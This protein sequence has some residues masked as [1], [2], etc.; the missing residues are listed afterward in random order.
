MPRQLVRN[1][2][3]VY[4]AIDSTSRIE[5]GS[6]PVANSV[7]T[8]SMWIKRNTFNAVSAF[9]RILSTQNPGLSVEFNENLGNLSYVNNTGR[10][11]TSTFRP[12]AKWF[13]L[14]AVR[15]ATQ[16][17]L[18][19]NGV[20]VGTQPAGTSTDTGNLVIG[21]LSNLFARAFMGN[22]SDFT[23]YNKELSQDEINNVMN[24][25]QTTGLL[26]WFKLDEGTGS[27]AIDSSPNGINGTI[28][29]GGW[30]SDS[31]VK[32]RYVG[33][34][35][36]PVF[37]GDFSLIPPGNVPT[38][39]TGRWIDGTAAGGATNIY[40]WRLLIDNV[41][42]TADF[43]DG[44]L[45]IS[46]ANSSA[47]GYADN[48]TTAAQIPLVGDVGY[49]LSY[50]LKTIRGAGGGG[51]GARIEMTVSNNGATLYST[52]TPSVISSQDWTVY[53]VPFYAPPNATHL[54]LR[55]RLNGD[56]VAWFD[57]ITITRAPRV[58]NVLRKDPSNLIIN[59][60]FEYFPVSSVPQNTATSWINGTPA[61]ST[62]KQY[63]WAAF[64]FIGGSSVMFD[65]AQKYSGAASMKLMGI[66][67]NGEAAVGKYPFPGNLL[68][69][70]NMSEAAPGVSYTVSGMLKT[71]GALGNGL[72]L[73][74]RFISA[75]GALLN[76]AVPS[77]IN[78]TTDWTPSSISMVAPAG[79]AW[80]MP[81]LYFSG[82]GEGWVDN[83][84]LKTTTPSG[85]RVPVS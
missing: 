62:D 81:M 15:T 84:T 39:V 7:F 3:F 54:R 64:F 1:I 30:S 46:N 27:V 73:R 12:I 49:V 22:I 35:A 6:N 61:G 52:N 53:S 74:M 23:L 57:D 85:Q 9:P 43:N 50:R 80:V 68:N 60:D 77:S 16:I 29:N 24:G 28:V 31:P 19:Q 79:T 48:G 41:G 83:V 13:F 45:R 82:V 14:T 5:I 67:T 25:V 42:T 32:L 47:A 70:H 51:S 69:N 36:S 76:T 18:Y 38:D 75:T 37:N 55:L 34:A 66:N 4:N 78:G 63:G 8:A 26:R 65:T 56:L 17:K 10:I 20:L 58:K 21:N 40:G 11:D 2:P 44:G 72:S 33:E 59:G 71:I